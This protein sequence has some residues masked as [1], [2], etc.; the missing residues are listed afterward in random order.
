MDEELKR[1]LEESGADVRTTIGRFMGNEAMYQKFLGKF[2]DDQNYQNLG[3]YLSEGNFEEAY[4]CA[5]TLKGVAANL[6][7]DPI[8]KT[9]S[10][11]VEELRG[12]KP[13][14][15]DA[16]RADALWHEVEKAYGVFHDIIS[17]M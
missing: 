4:K 17:G 15:V 9:S 3:K 10:D 2:L 12:K 5:H 16:A 8:Q 1:R 14:E 6:G 13:E 11:L 7:L